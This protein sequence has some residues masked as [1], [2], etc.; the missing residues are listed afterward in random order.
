M[1]KSSEFLREKSRGRVGGGNRLSPPAPVILGLVPGI[2]SQQGTNLVNKLALLFHK[3]WLREDSWDK[4][5]NDGCRGRGF[6][7]YS[8]S[9]RSM[10]EML[11][12]LAIIAVL[13]VGG[14]AGYSKA[15]EKWKINKAVEQYS[16]IINGLIKPADELK[17]RGD[18]SGQMFYSYINVVEALGLLPSSWYDKNTVGIRDDLG[19]YLQ[20]FVRNKLVV[21]DFYL[22]GITTDDDGY[23]SSSFSPKLCQEIVQNVFYPLHSVLHH[24]FLVKDAYYGDAFCGS[25]KC[26]AE[27]KP[28][29][30]NALC[31]ACENNG[32]SSCV[33][34]F[35]M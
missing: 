7:A 10:I 24:V 12:V 30:I 15:M 11:G 4:P 13:S 22:G 23:K 6:S 21:I 33:L 3:C 31:R 16:C 25:K 2:L 19:N 14:I 9:G 35:E 18:K 5:K 29:E 1:L 32:K 26:L 28:S 17:I 34:V 8:Q 27:I 20:F